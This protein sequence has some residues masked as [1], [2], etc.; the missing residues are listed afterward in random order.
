M[1]TGNRRGEEENSAK[2]G[3]LEVPC[4][5]VY[6]CAFVG[7]LKHCVVLD[8]DSQHLFTYLQAFKYCHPLQ[9]WLAGDE[10]RNP[11]TCQDY[12]SAGLTSTQLRC[13]VS[14][15]GV[16][17]KKT[18]G[19][20][21]SGRRDTTASLGVPANVFL[22]RSDGPIYKWMTRHTSSIL[23]HTNNAIWCV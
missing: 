20:R 10:G 12:P 8:P 6:H 4:L 1:T 21:S 15:V 3:V 23:R 17:H 7:P 16:F 22:H 13:I 11:N 18:W 9:K 5:S 2:V 19:L 14:S